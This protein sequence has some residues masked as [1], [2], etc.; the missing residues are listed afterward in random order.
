MFSRPLAFLL[1]ALATITA[2]A[3]GAY[4]ASRH[5]VTDQPAAAAAPAA[6]A[7][8]KA[9][10]AAPQPVAETEAPVSS[11]KPEDPKP[12]PATA[13]AAKSNPAS[14]ASPR[15]AEPAT[16]KRTATSPAQTKSAQHTSA[17]ASHPG[18]ANGSVPVTQA[19][20][21]P[22]TAQPAAPA[23]EPVRPVEPQPEPRREPQFEQ[24]ILPAASVIGLQLDTPLSSERARVEDRVD[25]HVTRDVMAGGR[26]AIPTG[27]RV[28]GSVVTVE[29]GGK[30]KEPARLA[31]R[32]HTLIFAD[33]SEVQLHTEPIDRRSES[34]AGSSTKKI[35]GAAVAGTILGAIIGGGKGAATGGA[36][37]AGAGTAAVMAGDRSTVTIPTGALLNARLS[38]PA[39]IT[40]ERRDQ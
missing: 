39:T 36:I 26:V 17:P 32:F 7:A 15:R 24:V 28:I 5:N 23:P 40:V 9:T 37:G 29:R 12:E 25:A 33:G 21:Q 6:P 20:P 11:A 16:A 18:S 2:A 1:L 3:G 35:G 31:I 14:A 13:P 27:T 10:T 38:A 22:A 30:V 19:D 8:S 4:V 34:P